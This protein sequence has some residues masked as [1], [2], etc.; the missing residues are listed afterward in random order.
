ML[1]GDFISVI[2]RRTVVSMRQERGAAPRYA[3][4]AAAIRAQI[5]A[6]H[7]GGPGARIPSE[8]E[9]IDTYGVSKTTA[10]GALK[11]L[12]AEGLIVRRS[13]AGSF[14]AAHPPQLQTVE[15]CPG[16]RISARPANAEDFVGSLEEIPPGV[17]A[18]VIEIPGRPVRVYPADRTHLIVLAEYRRP[19][20]APPAAAVARQARTRDGD[21]VR[22]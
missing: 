3:Q 1:F 2:S 21:S 11:M 16:A 6:G 12:S 14:I 4:I 22:G 9:I 7:L 18:L 15:V 8:P 20:S 5:I 17:P 19:S 13:G 10:I